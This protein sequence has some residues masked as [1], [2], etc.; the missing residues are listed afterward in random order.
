LPDDPDFIP[1]LSG[2]SIQQR[3]R[4]EAAA[5][6]EVAQEQGREERRQALAEHRRLQAE[7]VKNSISGEE[8]GLPPLPPFLEPGRNNR[9]DPHGHVIQYWDF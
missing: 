6:N 5:R 7:I 1:A 2:S 3:A 4:Q 9:K 8:S